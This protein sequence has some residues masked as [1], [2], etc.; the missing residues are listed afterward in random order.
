MSRTRAH[1]ALGAVAVVLATA[2][3]GWAPVPPAAAHGELLFSDPSEGGLLGALPSR[4]FLT[5]TDPITEIHEVT[6][7]GPDGSVTH[8]APTSV[9]PEVRQ[10]LWAGPDGAYTLTYHVVSADGHEIS[11][12]VGFEVGS[13]AAATADQSAARDAA[14]AGSGGG[15]LGATLPVALVLLA[16]GAA[17]MLVRRRRTAG[18]GT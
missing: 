13:G 5:F 11:G 1:R 7:T 12:Q 2:L 18:P 8:G 4:A 6:V 14:P 9:G 16:G 10:T 17:L 15:V 3:L